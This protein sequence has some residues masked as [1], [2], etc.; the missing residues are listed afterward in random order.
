[1]TI[2]NRI[3]IHGFKS[4]AHKTDVPFDGKYNC[5]LGPNGSG[6]SNV[7]DALCFV[8]GRISAKSMRAEKAAN[9]IFNGG[10][11]KSPAQKAYV[12]IAFDNKEKIFPN[13]EE[14]VVVNRTIKQ[15]GTSIYRVNDKKMTRSEVVDLLSLAKINPD[16]YNIILQ[17]DIMR[18]VD[19][20]PLER[21]QTIEE[22]SDVSAYEEKKHKAILELEK[23]EEKL[24]NATLILKER[25]THL[26][27]LKKDRDQA[28]KFKEA[29]DT[30][31]NHKATLIHLHI[32]E[33]EE[34][35]AK[36]DK[37][38]SERQQEISKSEKKLVELRE[39][40]SKAKES[41]SEI[42]K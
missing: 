41:I 11:N 6:K 39:L 27:E 30:I 15:D 19:M 5:I 12:E 9:L 16:G 26:H 38:I 8:L 31:N 3:T 7:G 35:K 40:I 21:R 37:E 42:N 20:S 33:R 10:K 2:I 22:I 36:F 17:G 32:K 14:E 24:N 18:F 23:V 34:V 13:P 29:K 1:M 25:K 28:L 4:F